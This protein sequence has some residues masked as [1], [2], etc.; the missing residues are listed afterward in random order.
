MYGMQ[1]DKLQIF[2]QVWFLFS[3]ISNYDCYEYET[4]DNNYNKNQ[5]GLEIFKIKIT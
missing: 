2:K 3:F 1:L 4:K 5:S